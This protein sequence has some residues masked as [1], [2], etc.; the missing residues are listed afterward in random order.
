MV[1]ITANEA[2]SDA[3][4]LSD[5][6]RGRSTLAFAIGFG[7]AALLTATATIGTMTAGRSSDEASMATR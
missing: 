3:A 4:V 6:P 1:Q 2:A 7:L 5:R